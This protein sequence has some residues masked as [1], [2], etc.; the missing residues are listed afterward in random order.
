MQTSKLATW[1]KKA[2]IQSSWNASE[3]H[4]EMSSL[5]VVV[6]SHLFLALVHSLFIWVGREARWRQSLSVRTG[7][8]GEV[9]A[10]NRGERAWHSGVKGS[11]GRYSQ[12]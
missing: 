3:T 10:V 7:D 2:Y 11:G 9:A 1:Q 8:R 5:L 12:P 6:R 4:R